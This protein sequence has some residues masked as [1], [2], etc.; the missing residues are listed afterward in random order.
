ML[1]TGGAIDV[2]AEEKI[3]DLTQPFEGPGAR[4]VFELRDRL[5]QS[6]WEHAGL[7]RSE[8]SLNTGAGELANIREELENVSLSNYGRTYHLEW[9]EYCNLQN[10]LDVCEAII[11]SALTRKESRGSHYRSDF[12]EKDDENFLCNI[13]LTRHQHAPELRPVKF[14]RM[15]PNDPAPIHVKTSS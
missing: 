12:P 6:M 7:V 11:K 14:T 1:Y 15:K 13:L 9:M 4:S 5:K 8:T 10:Y 3:K 2:E